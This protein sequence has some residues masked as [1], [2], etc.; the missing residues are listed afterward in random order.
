MVD[1]RGHQTLQVDVFFVSMRAIYPEWI[2]IKHASFIIELSWLYRQQRCFTL[3]KPA[4]LVLVRPRDLGWAFI[5]E[6]RL[7]FSA[8]CLG[9]FIR[10]WASIRGYTVASRPLVYSLHTCEQCKLHIA[11]SLYNILVTKCVWVSSC[12]AV[13]HAKGIPSTIHYL[14]GSGIYLLLVYILNML[15]FVSIQI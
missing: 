12:T 5:R 4:P 15:H 8:N 9:A 3:W 1:Y 7:F 11:V 14:S 10:G 6:G 13:R 2:E